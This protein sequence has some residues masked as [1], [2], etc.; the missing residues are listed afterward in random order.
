MTTREAAQIVGKDSIGHV[1]YR[2]LWE[3]IRAGKMPPP[4]KNASGDYTWTETDLENARKAI[5]S[6]RRRRKAVRP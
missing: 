6:D 1:S 3:Q 5:V 2:R 4:A